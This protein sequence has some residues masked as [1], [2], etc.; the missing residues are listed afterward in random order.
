MRELSDKCTEV[1][2]NYIELDQLLDSS[3]QYLNEN[4]LILHCEVIFL[5]HD[6]EII[7]DLT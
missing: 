2:H 7:N 3:P 1:D 5:S 4:D 6:H